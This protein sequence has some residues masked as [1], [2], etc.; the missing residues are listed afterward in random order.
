MS[1]TADDRKW[2]RKAIREETAPQ[3]A[4][5][6]KLIA[7]NMKATGDLT[8]VVKDLVKEAGRSGRTCARATTGKGRAPDP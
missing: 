6:G 3:F 4:A 2:I 5:H 8:R 1:L 7:E